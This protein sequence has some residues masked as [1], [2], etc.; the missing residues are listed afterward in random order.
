MFSGKPSVF[1]A[2]TFIWIVLVG[3]SRLPITEPVELLEVHTV[4]VLVTSFTES[5]LGINTIVY[6][7][8]SNVCLW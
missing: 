1:D 6:I 7:F 3:A 5:Y 4:D 2:A 8:N